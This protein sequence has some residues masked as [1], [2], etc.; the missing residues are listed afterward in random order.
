VEVGLGIE[1]V[2]LW[3]EVLKLNMGSRGH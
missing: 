2:E 3:K 1:N